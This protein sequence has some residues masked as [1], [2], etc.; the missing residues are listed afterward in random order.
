[1][2]A[3]TMHCSGHDLIGLILYFA[4]LVDCVKQ[5][6]VV[7]AANDFIERASQP[8]WILQEVFELQ[9]L[10]PVQEGRMVRFLPWALV[11]IVPSVRIGRFE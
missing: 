5:G 10:A 7:G 9:I 6:R 4:Q 3:S 1:M 11:Q 2:R 8:G